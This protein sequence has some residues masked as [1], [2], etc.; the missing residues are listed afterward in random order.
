MSFDYP[1]EVWQANDEEITGG[2]YEVGY[3]RRKVAEL[4]PELAAALDGDR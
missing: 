3:V 4:W 2:G 1:E